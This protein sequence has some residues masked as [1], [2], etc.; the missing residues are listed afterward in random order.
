MKLKLE[1]FLTWKL[2]NKETLTLNIQHFELPF[3][4]HVALLFLL[5]DLNLN[6]S[7]SVY[8][9]KLLVII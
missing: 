1:N 5:L 8:I 4:L 7:F 3:G 2:I 9:V 6:I